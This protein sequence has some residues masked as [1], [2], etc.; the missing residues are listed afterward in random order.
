M[1]FSSI[2]KDLN[3]ELI[4]SFI[5]DF[6]SYTKQDIAKGIGLSFPTVSKVIDEMVEKKI[7]DIL[8]DKKVA[9]VEE[10]HSCIN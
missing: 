10:G 5:R 8:E 7:I 9:L 4:I 2:A 6:K 1:A 3:K